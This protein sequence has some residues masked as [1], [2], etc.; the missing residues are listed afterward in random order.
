[1]I[2]STN[3]RPNPATFSDEDRAALAQ[4]LGTTIDQVQFTAIYEEQQG[5]PG[6]R[7]EATAEAAPVVV[8]PATTPV[9]E[10]APVE[11]APAVEAVAE[12]SADHPSE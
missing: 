2:A 10:V 11:T 1:M 3:W 9:A 8:A 7:L 5:I 12:V 4:E 6:H